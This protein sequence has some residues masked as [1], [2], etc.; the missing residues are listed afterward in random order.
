MSRNGR[1]RQPAC[2]RARIAGA[3]A[4]LIAVDGITDYGLAKKKAIR[5]LGLSENVSMPDNGE[6][7]E[8]LRTYQTLYQGNE[9][10]E[11]L[12]H[13][14]ELA[15]ETMELL[16]DFNPYLT[17][18]V[19]DGSA[20]RYADID[21]L[22]FADSAKEVEIFLLNRGLVFEH[23]EPPNERVEAVLLLNAEDADIRLSVLDPNLE[24][25]VFRGR[26]GRVHERARIEAVRTLI[27][28]QLSEQ[29][30]VAI[31]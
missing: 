20:G 9:H 6:V 3:A 25:T 30:Q 2:L 16:I 21:V 10:R 1:L 22:L 23:L 4:R 26:D 7:E 17:G 5:Q 12:R 28:D 19:L 27:D 13:L 11:T 24:R 31:D 15:V 8:A 29:S 18:S 14:R